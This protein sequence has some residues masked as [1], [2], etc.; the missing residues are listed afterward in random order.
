MSFLCGLDLGQAHDFSALVI[1]EAIEETIPRTRAVIN[2]FVQHT[3]AQKMPTRYDVRHIQRFTLGTSYPAIVEQVSSLL[4][5]PELGRDVTLIV[6]G[7]GVGRPVVDLFRQAGGRHGFVPV[8]I[9]GGDTPSMVDGWRHVPKRE[10]IAVVQVLLQSGRLRIGQ[11]P[12]T[13]VLTS[14]LQ[15][16]RVKVTAAAHETFNAREGTHDD[17]VLA[18]ALA[19]WFG[20]RAGHVSIRWID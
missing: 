8:V 14:E 9:T 16:Y 1:A 11:F 13:A 19:T 3:P 4:R 12:E 10:L 2:G 20:E 17:L 7:T 18:L 6:D 5:R 15:N